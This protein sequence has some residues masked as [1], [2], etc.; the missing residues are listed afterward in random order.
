MFV[1]NLNPK[2][3]YLQI[4]ELAH[5]LSQHRE[6]WSYNTGISDLQNWMSQNGAY[7]GIRRVEKFR[8][9]SELFISWKQLVVFIQFQDNSEP[10]VGHIHKKA[11]EVLARIKARHFQDCW[12]SIHA[13]AEGHLEYHTQF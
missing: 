6:G 12:V 1:K 13:V 9:S 8:V 2:I 11:Y 5:R 7:V 10:P 3:H 4:T